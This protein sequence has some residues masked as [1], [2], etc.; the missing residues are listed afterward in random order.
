MKKLS[1]LLAV[2]FLPFLAIA[3]EQRQYVIHGDA[4]DLDGFEIALMSDNNVLGKTVIKDGVFTITG[5]LT[6][7]PLVT[8]LDIRSP[9]GH[10]AYKIM[11]EETEYFVKFNKDEMF[12]GAMPEIRSNSVADN[13]LRNADPVIMRITHQRDSLVKLYR[14]AVMKGDDQLLP[15]LHTAYNNSTEEWK[16]YARKLV[17]SDPGNILNAYAGLS[18]PIADTAYFRDLYNHLSEK[19]KA[20]Q[21]GEMFTRKITTGRLSL[22]Y[23]EE[24]ARKLMMYGGHSAKD[25]TLNDR[26]GET[27][28]LSDQKGKWVLLDFWASWCAPCRAEFPALKNAWEKFNVSGLSII[29][30]SIDKDKE[31]WLKAIA[32]DHTDMFTHLQQPSGSQSTVAK[33]Y[34]VSYVPT[35]FLINPQGRIIASDI[36]GRDLEKILEEQI[37]AGQ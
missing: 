6:Q 10:G 3:Q 34:N 22:P 15:D 14:S 35:N 11:L 16:A 2:I 33:L 31:A 9:R 7:S 26:N 13:N 1:V 27:F 29:S 21:I 18:V 8:M 28:R 32:D 23:P 5:S 19:I 17:L 25:F 36:R 37:T 24:S 4:K 12:R 20:S 30:I